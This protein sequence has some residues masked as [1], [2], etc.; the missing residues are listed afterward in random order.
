VNPNAPWRYTAA[1]RR[2]GSGFIVAQIYKVR[3]SNARVIL[4]DSIALVLRVGHII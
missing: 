4:G 3:L 2:L 1:K